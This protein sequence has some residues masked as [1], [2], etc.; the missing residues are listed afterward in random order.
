[1]SKQEVLTDLENA[2]KVPENYK[3][4]WIFYQDLL[5]RTKSHLQKDRNGV[6]D[7][8]KYWL[9]LKDEVRTMYSVDLIKNLAIKE[10]K[11]ELEDLK[12]DI[13]SR[14]AFLP[15]YVQWVDAALKALS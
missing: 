10:L 4:G 11:P 3:D 7:A 9:S 12:Q 13:I 8:L 15:Y 1:M 6:I 5:A 2:F 14:K